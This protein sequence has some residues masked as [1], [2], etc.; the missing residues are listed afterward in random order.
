MRPGGAGSQAWPPLPAPAMSPALCTGSCD[1]ARHGG[2]EQR[3]ASR[4]NQW[5]APSASAHVPARRGGKAEAK[6]ALAGLWAQ[7]RWR[8]V[9]RK[10]CLEG[11]CVRS[12]APALNSSNCLPAVSDVQ[13]HQALG[14]L[15]SN[16]AAPREQG[17]SYRAGSQMLSLY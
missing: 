9:N 16:P 17:N 1:A 2:T 11:R 4:E 13:T 5:P 15:P 7:V 10:P 8:W 14:Q 12:F 6:E 3:R